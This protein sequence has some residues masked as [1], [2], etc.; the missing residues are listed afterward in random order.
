M[1]NSEPS[2]SKSDLGLGIIDTACLFCVAGS[3]W[4]ANYK[5]LLEDFGLKHEIDET[6][7]AERYKFGD[8]GTLVS[9][10][11]ETAPIFVA[12]KKGRI[13]F[14]VVP[15]KH[16][17]LLIGRDFLTPA[18][19]V[20]DMGEKTLRIG[21]G[22]D[23]FG[24]EPSWTP[25]A[26]IESARLAQRGEFDRGYSSASPCEAE[27]TGPSD[28]ETAPINCD[29]FDQFTLSFRS[30]CLQKTSR[31]CLKNVAQLPHHDEHP[32][33]CFVC[34]VP[35]DR[36]CV[37]C[38]HPVC[39]DCSHKTL[40]TKC[41]FNV[42]DKNSCSNVSSSLV[43]SDCVPAEVNIVEEEQNMWRRIK[44]GTKFQL[45]A[46]RRSA[47]LL[48]S[49]QVKP[50]FVAESLI[51]S[52]VKD[53]LSRT[54]RETF[55]ATRVRVR[56]RDQPE[57][58]LTSEEERRLIASL[59]Q[60]HT[61]LGH[62]SN[63]ALARAIRVTGGSAAAVRATLQLRCDVCESQ[64][65]PG[66]HLPARFRKDRKFGDTA[67]I[68]LFV[69]ADYE[70]NQ[71][72]FINIPDL[73]STFGVVAMIPSKH[74]KIVWD[75]FVKHWITP[76]GVPR[77]LI[78]DQGG[79]FEREF[80]QEL[81]D[82][83]CEPMPTAAITP[84]QNAVCERH[85]GIWKTHA[86]RLLDE[87]SV[88]FVPEQLHSVTWLTAAVI[89]A[90]NSAIDDSGYSPAQ[91]VLGRGL[92]LPYTLLDQTERLSLHERLTRDRAFSERIAMMSAAQRTITSLRY[93]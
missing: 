85:G 45:D 4:W 91:W 55:P 32:R 36:C 18:R 21:T 27:E 26:A 11:R 7:E 19:A 82:L 6:R 69:L 51:T 77:K 79:E 70:G 54:P 9:S 20:V 3:D 88:K 46:G 49:Q 12:G 31:S 68:D 75:H 17:P 78:Y 52:T 25:G 10:I 34:S 64:Q 72:S 40:C 22:V 93:V 42:D 24:R 74:P 50:H 56:P 83:G 89:W 53:A 30:E 43:E 14:S 48:S 92:R 87:F 63:H 35:S 90:C 47:L 23:R 37:A 5:S 80:G 84:Q 28:R 62:P 61:N 58:D 15:S 16:L 65:H 41:V 59:R 57:P 39:H 67:A 33:H 66:P 2:A 1:E 76:F 73:A 86:R 60:M 8:G 38:S 44:K 29:S 81:E 13:V 71:L